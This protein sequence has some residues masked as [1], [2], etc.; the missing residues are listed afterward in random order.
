MHA[1]SRR[2]LAALVVGWLLG[3]VTA[4]VMPTL[5]SERQSMIVFSART[6]PD[7]NLDVLMK[8]LSEGWH[9]TRQEGSVYT[10]ERPRFRLP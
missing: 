6:H 2:T 1:M 7:Y 8:R 5:V 3:I 9:V 10:L 4:L